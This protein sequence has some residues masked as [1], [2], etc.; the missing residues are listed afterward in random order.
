[1]LAQVFWRTARN[2]RLCTERDLLKEQL[3]KFKRQRIGRQVPQAIL[4]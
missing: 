2:S 1:M 4:D 3:N